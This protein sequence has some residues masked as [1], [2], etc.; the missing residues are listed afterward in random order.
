LSAFGS[1]RLLRRRTAAI[2]ANFRGC[3]YPEAAIIVKKGF[4]RL[5][6]DDE[7]PLS[8]RENAPESMSFRWMRA[9]KGCIFWVSAA[10]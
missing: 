8:I 10:I 1:G 6:I 9:E 2:L 3:A 7:L 5:P 4:S